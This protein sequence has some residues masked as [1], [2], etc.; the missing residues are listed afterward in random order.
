MASEKS[1]SGK[2]T[3]TGGACQ[4]INTNVKTRGIFSLT[5]QLPGLV[6]E[7][8]SGNAC[9]ASRV[10]HISLTVPGSFCALAQKGGV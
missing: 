8:Q 10:P 5:N 6:R 1:K 7:L 2:N 9:T 3:L 4:G